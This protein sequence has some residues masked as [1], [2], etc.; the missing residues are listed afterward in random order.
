MVQHLAKTIK[1]NSAAKVAEG[2]KHEKEDGLWG[3]SK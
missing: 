1:R 2:S 3:Y